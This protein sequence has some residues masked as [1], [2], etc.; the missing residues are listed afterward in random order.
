MN[1]KALIK[2]QIKELLPIYIISFVLIAVI[3]WFTIMASRMMPTVYGF[4]EGSDNIYINYY[5]A[6]P[7]LFAIII[8]TLIASTIWPIAIFS[9]Q[10]SHIRSDFFC[11][12]PLKEKELRK[13]R[14]FL[15]LT[16]LEVITTFVYWIGI[17]FIATAQM[18]ANAN[19]AYFIIFPYYYQYGYFVLYYLILVIAIALNFFVSSYFISLGTRTIESIMYLI[20]GQLFLAF[21]FTSI[22][23]P[24]NSIASYKER[25]ATLANLV[26]SLPSFSWLESCMLTNVMN[27]LIMKSSYSIDGIELIARIVSEIGY[28]LVGAACIYVMMAKKDPSGEYAGKPMP[29]NTYISLYP[30]IFSL[31]TGL[32]IA[33][34]IGLLSQAVTGWMCYILW[35]GAYYFIIVAVNG[36][37]HFKVRNWIYFGAVCS[38]TLIMSIIIYLV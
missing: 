10:T 8:P 5:E 6:T 7:P 28:L 32:L 36:G 24:I 20:F 35:A 12:I 33:T 38:V 11:Q 29:I 18:S 1:K 2:W 37:F 22:L 21:V 25:N 27:Q 23:L 31:M 30:H 13:I 16:I 4:E 15:N 9:Y 17:L 26:S 34:G 3:F 14:I 19:E